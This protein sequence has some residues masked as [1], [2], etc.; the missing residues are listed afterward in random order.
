MPATDTRGAAHVLL[1]EQRMPNSPLQDLGANVNKNNATNDEG[2]VVRSA[3]IGY[4]CR[5]QIREVGNS[6]ANTNP[7]KQKVSHPHVV[8]K[9]SVEKTISKQTTKS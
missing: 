6:L 1:V 9:K 4:H 8:T 7:D 2:I 3:P 5:N